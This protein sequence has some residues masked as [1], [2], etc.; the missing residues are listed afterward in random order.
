M[1]D[2]RK[3]L[4][5]NYFPEHAKLQYAYSANMNRISI[6]SQIFL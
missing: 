4:L 2:R 6:E 5:D 3:D 1:G